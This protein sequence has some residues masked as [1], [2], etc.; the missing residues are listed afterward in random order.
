MITADQVRCGDHVF[1]RP[2]RETW[3]VAWAEG[4][5]MAW[6][7]WP[8]GA[9]PL[10]DCL[11]VYRATDAEHTE[12]VRE[13]AKAGD[14]QGDSRRARVLRLYGMERHLTRDEQAIMDAALRRSLRIVP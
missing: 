13:W 14:M 5:Y 1:H 7:G 12:A 8:N 9:A 2:S 3:L 4:E 11:L 6:A 10:R